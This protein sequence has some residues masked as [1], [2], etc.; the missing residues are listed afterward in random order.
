LAIVE[1]LAGS[2]PVSERESVRAGLLDV[3]REAHRR[4]GTLVPEWME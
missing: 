2:V 3:L 4:A 1:L